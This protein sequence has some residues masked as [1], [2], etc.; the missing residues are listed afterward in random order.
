[1]NTT[2]M[3][4]LWA[5][6]QMIFFLQFFES[7]TKQFYVNKKLKL[8]I[9][10][11]IIFQKASCIVQYGAMPIHGLTHD[12]QLRACPSCLLRLMY[13]FGVNVHSVMPIHGLIYDGQLRACPCALLGL[14]YGLRQLYAIRYLGF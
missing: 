5:S 8:K 2:Y 6:L 14:I 3:C 13:V 11:T 10:Y 9:S 1:M 7:C 12:G 4:K